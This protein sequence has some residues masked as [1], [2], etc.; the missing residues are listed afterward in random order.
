MCIRDSRYDYSFSIKSVLSTQ[1]EGK[2]FQFPLFI[3][4]SIARHGNNHATADF[5]KLLFVFVC[6]ILEVCIVI[7][8][9]VG[10]AVSAVFAGL[11][12]A[13]LRAGLSAALLS[14]KLFTC[15]LYTSRCV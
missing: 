7:S 1:T 11:S 5:H 6:F 9:S 12:S 8:V 3:C 14:V 15:L 10:S 2:R 4:L 13:V